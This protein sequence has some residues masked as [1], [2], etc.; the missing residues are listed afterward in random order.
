MCQRSAVRGAPEVFLG[1]EQR[2]PNICNKADIMSTF[3]VPFEN[4]SEEI[5]LGS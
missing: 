1:Q 2:D 3:K 4:G 5:F